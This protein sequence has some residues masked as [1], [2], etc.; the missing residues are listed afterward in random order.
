MSELK[1][2]LTKKPTRGA[3]RTLTAFST[4]MYQLLSQKAFEQISVNEIC[5]LSNFP[6]ATFYNYFDDKYDLV[7]YCWYI[8]TQEIHLDDVK[9]ITPDLNLTP[10]QA[11]SIFFDRVYQLFTTH[12]QLLTNILKNNSLNSP[13]VL[14]FTD[15]VRANMREIIYNCLDFSAVPVP[16]D[17]IADHYSNTVLLVLE[18]TFVRRADVTLAEAHQYLEYLLKY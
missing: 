15:F 13:M 11:L 3:Q 12:S 18:W 8:L 6:R 16:L 7:N 2:D 5:E 4:T 10:K 17:L 9:K 1:Y 14:N